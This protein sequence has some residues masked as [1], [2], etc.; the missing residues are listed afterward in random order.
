[1]HGFGSS[2]SAFLQPFTV[3]AKQSGQTNCLL[4]ELLVVDA[5]VAEVVV[6][7]VV[8]AAADDVV[9]VSAVAAVVWQ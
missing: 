1:M 6:S 2:T 4:C 7:A 3:A 9:V 5:A 8:T